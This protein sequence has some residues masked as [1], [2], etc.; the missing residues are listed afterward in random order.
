MCFICKSTFEHFI[1]LRE[2]LNYVQTD[3]ART[4]VCSPYKLVSHT[5]VVC[6][7]QVISSRF[8]VE[9]SSLYTLCKRN[10][11]KGKNN[12]LVCVLI[13]TRHLPSQSSALWGGFSSGWES[14][15]SGALPLDRR[16]WF[17]PASLCKSSS[18]GG[19]SGSTFSCFSDPPAGEALTKLRL[20]S[21]EGFAAAC[22]EP[23]LSASSGL[24]VLTGL[25][26]SW[27]LG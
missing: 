23:C 2:V 25:I 27:L 12:K 10:I 15:G 9:V 16:A 8:E 3:D 11:K 18:V 22:E 7:W 20:L 14:Q 4:G 19:I 21:S 17:T 13:C 24:V 5:S 1:L 6:L 26:L